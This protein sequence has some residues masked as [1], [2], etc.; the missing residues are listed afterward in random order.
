MSLTGMILAFSS[1]IA[2]RITRSPGLDWAHAKRLEAERDRLAYERDQI[3][4]YADLI[5]RELAT[6]R[7]MA[8]HWL[9]E[10]QQTIR[11]RPL[12]PLALGGQHVAITPAQ[13]HAHVMAQHAQMQAQQ[14]PQ[15]IGSQQAMAEMQAHRNAF[16]Q[17]FDGFCNCVPGRSQLFYEQQ[18]QQQNALV[19]QLN[20]T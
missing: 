4:N 17:Q 9:R 13:Q 1:A 14:Q 16:N 10:L 20:R 2:A 12:P 11:E 7:S 8:D 3:R 5:E 15:W 19:N 18:A 6:Q